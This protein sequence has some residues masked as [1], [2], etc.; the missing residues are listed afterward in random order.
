MAIC[1]KEGPHDHRVVS[2]RTHI[3]LIVIRSTALADRVRRRSAAFGGHLLRGVVHR[4][5]ACTPRHSEL[6]ISAQRVPDGSRVLRPVT[7][8]RRSFVAPRLPVRSV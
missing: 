8:R 6:Y 3:V 7:A 5:D 4:L 1:A 2:V